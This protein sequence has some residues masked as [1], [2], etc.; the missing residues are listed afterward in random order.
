MSAREHILRRVRE[1]LAAHPADDLR[2]A[3]VEERMRTHRRGTTPA[4][5]KGEQT[6]I[7]ALFVA[8][9]K[10]ADASV[11]V[12][13]AIDVPETIA[14]FLRARNLGTDVRM[15][16]DP[17]LTGL[18][19]ERAPE[20][21]VSHGP[22]DALTATGIT[23]AVAA[24]AETGT[25]ILAS[26]ADNPTTLNFLPETHIAIVPAS[27]IG[28]TYE[29][30]WERLRGARPETEMPRVINFVTGPSRTADIEQTLLMGAHGPRRLHVIVVEDA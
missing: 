6:A 25:V 12:V 7:C 8:M 15:G 27:A 28:A 19:W 20:L 21:T 24:A 2:R 3:R 11:D 16:T 17:F 26:G 23:G 30:A 1:G 18:A 22:A 14:A 10:E 4:R 13:R 9:A 29:D 5:A